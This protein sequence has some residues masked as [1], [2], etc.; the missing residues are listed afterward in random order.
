M[1]GRNMKWIASGGVVCVL[2]SA[3]TLV[4]AQTLGDVGAASAASNAM[5][6]GS[7]SGTM[8]VGSRA[9]SD[10]RGLGGS[11][12]MG[13]RNPS[14]YEGMGSEMGAM[15]G[16]GSPDF[17]GVAGGSSGG[18]YGDGAMGGMGAAPPPPPRAVRWGKETGMDF[19]RELLN[20]PT[21]AKATGKIGSHQLSK[22][23]LAK[24]PPKTRS[25]II[26]QQYQKPPVG[27]L[28][29]Y[30]PQDRYK[31]T[32]SVWRYVLIED[33]RARYPVKYYWAPSSPAFLRILAQRPIK[34]QPRYNRV[35]GFHTW[36]EAMLAGYRPDPIS[37]PAPAPQIVALSNIS[38]RESLARYVEFVYGGQI[39]PA[40]FERNYRYITRVRGIIG[41]RKDLG[42]YMKP[43][44]SQILLAATGIGEVPRQVG[45]R[46]PIVT[47]QTGNVYNAGGGSG[48]GGT[49]AGGGYGGTPA[50][51][52]YGSSS[53]GDA[54]KGD[55]PMGPQTSRPSLGR[56]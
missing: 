14:N 51:G 34:S 20:Q 10:A 18:A 26:A 7:N 56:E 33:D 29:F 9:M 48:Y 49:P 3:S 41:A 37:K 30:L 32:S 38:S 55:E 47:I 54:P 22:K 1:A 4:N 16:S 25:K 45:P 17:P 5:N 8:A 31:V 50:G 39:S 6:A 28:S 24:L 35:I 43:T 46:P 15:G 40:V 42:A 11:P 2:M 44:I 53:M 13:G 27:Y 19:L 23:Q 52:G 12:M 21:R 36:Q